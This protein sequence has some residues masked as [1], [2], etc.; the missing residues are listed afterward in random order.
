MREIRFRAWANGN[1]HS[2]GFTSHDG[3]H[4]NCGRDVEDW[5]ESNA[6]IMQY[7]GLKD[8]N[9][10]DIYEGDLIK[11]SKDRVGKVVWHKPSASF[12]V[13]FVSDPF[14]YNPAI[15]YSYG[16]KNNMWRNHVKVI[17]NIYENPEL[18]KE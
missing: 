6:P 11:N 10:V 4:F 14:K 13:E 5:S 12:D 2:M 1:M 17:G 18:L 15:D 16:F 9:G 8:K 7:T 3:Y